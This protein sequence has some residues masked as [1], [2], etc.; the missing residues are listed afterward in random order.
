MLT[1]VEYAFW[2]EMRTLS[3]PRAVAE[4]TFWLSARR[5]KFEPLI[6]TRSLF[7]AVDLDT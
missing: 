3:R 7:C 5:V 6:W 4:G 2:L 1:C